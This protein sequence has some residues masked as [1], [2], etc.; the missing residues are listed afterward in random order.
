MKL[1]KLLYYSQAWS[2]VW[3]EAP[4]FRERIEAWINGPVVR[5]IYEAHRGQFMVSGAPKGDPSLLSDVQRETVDSVLEHYAE[6]SAQ[7]LSDLT[8]TE[9]P[10]NLA[11]KDLPDD[12]RGNR[13][14]PH[15]VMAWYYGSLG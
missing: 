13:E 5:E 2:L 10:W 15:D 12:V 9:D 4:I 6:K 8:H 3:D 7:Y 1:Q 14:I 11:R